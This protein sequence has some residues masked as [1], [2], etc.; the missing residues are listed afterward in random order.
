MEDDVIAVVL[1]RVQRCLVDYL[2]RIP[3]VRVGAECDQ[4]FLVCKCQDRC[5]EHT[6][7]IIERKFNVAPACEP[8][9]K[10]RSVHTSRW[11]VRRFPGN[12][13]LINV[14]VPCEDK[15]HPVKLLC[16]S[17]QPGVVCI[18]QNLFDFCDLEITTL[19]EM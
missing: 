5:V 4:P 8:R 14:N 18:R 1:D 16:H 9:S 11:D 17:I 6:K 12:T 15:V 7:G 13:E 19:D 3:S 2:Y 10:R